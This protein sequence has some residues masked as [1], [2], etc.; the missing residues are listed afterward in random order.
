MISR[1]EPERK[2]L[3]VIVVG[4]GFGGL[5]AAIECRRR[6]MEVILLEK[7]KAIVSYGDVSDFFANSGRIINTWGDGA[8]A[9]RMYKASIHNKSHDIHKYDGEL[10]FSDSFTGV[11][12]PEEDE[13]ITFIGHRVEMHFIVYDYAVEIGVKFK[14]DSPVVDYFE[15]A[16]SAGVKTKSGELIMGDVVIAADGPK[17][18]AKLKI[19]GIQDK[20]I[21]G[22]Y[23]IYRSFFDVDDALFLGSHVHFIVFNWNKGRDMAWVLT[24]KDDHDIQESWS[25]PG[26]KEDVYDFLK[27]EAWSPILKA[28]VDKTPDD[29][30]V[31][32][33]FVYRDSLPTWLSNG[34][35]MAVIGD[36]AHTHLP[37][38]AQGASQAMED[39][40]TF[41]ICLEKSPDDVRLAFKAA[42]RIKES[43]VTN[44]DVWHGITDET[45]EMFR[46]NPEKVRVPRLEWVVGFDP[47]QAVYDN[48]DKVVEEIREGKQGTLA[49]LSMPAGGSFSDY[50]EAYQTVKVVE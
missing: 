13:S 5:A 25:F 35:R 40:V 1:T 22:G 10:I 3:T 44:R 42:E 21:N 39:A 29:R 18:L 26:C 17:S 37:T 49:E 50:I 45:W 12:S 19:L 38:S 11:D 16:L 41:A 36:A 34:G 15:N 46:K 32:Y 23:A 27:Q 8:V 2:P 4:A 7:H 47:M 9:R 43:G 14:F 48:Y 31:D 24:H 33:K 30:I 6:G 20:S 28:I